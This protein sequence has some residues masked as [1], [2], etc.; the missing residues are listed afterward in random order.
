MIA[1]LEGT[2]DGYG[3]DFVIVKV[4][5]ISIRVYVPSPASLGSVGERVRLRTSLQFKENY[6]AIYGFASSEEL[7]LFEML[8]SV[9]GNGPKA[10]LSM[11]SVMTSEQLS[12]AIAAGDIDML[13]QVPGLGKKMASRLVL[14][15]K[16]KLE[17]W[18]LSAAASPEAAVNS[19]VLAALKSLGYTTAEAMA[20]MAAIPDSTDLSLEDKIRLSLQQLGKA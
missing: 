12:L 6:I 5:G 11:L 10:A 7:E 13:T 2:L 9:S 14:E 3:N 19:E 4:G 20:A 18:Q 1:A 16:G 15:L 17:S 8:I